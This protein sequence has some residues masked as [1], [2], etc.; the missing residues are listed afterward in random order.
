MLKNYIT[1]TTTNLIFLHKVWVALHFSAF[2]GKM[3]KKMPT[4]T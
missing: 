4:F 3:C 2:S 1:N